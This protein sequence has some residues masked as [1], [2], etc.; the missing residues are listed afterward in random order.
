MQIGLSENCQTI[1]VD[2]QPIC[3]TKETNEMTYTVVSDKSKV[4]A[5]DTTSDKNQA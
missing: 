2:T 4:G 1:H 5:A 3:R